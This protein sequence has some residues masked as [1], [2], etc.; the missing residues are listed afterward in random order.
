MLDEVRAGSG[1][2]GRS[3]NVMIGGNRHLLLAL[4][5][6]GGPCALALV[7]TPRLGPPGP[8]PAT[9]S[10]PLALALVAGLVG[11]WPVVRRIRSM[12]LAV[13]RW[14]EGAPL[15]L[16]RDVGRDET[17]RALAGVHGFRRDHSSVSTRLSSRGR[18]RCSS[19]SRTRPTTSAT[20]LTVLQGNLSAMAKEHSPE[21]VRQAMKE[22]QYIGALLAESRGLGEVRGRGAGGDVPRPAVTSYPASSIGIAPW[23]NGSGSR[24]SARSPKNTCSRWATRRSPSGRS[25]TSSRTPRATT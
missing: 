13:R 20:P 16:P 1:P 21:A 8:P 19:S 15:G 5:R 12:T 4:P 14:D 11:I 3:F 6:E 17:Q 24:S 25:P 2:V 9:S 22:A 23:P 10:L 7:A 18:R